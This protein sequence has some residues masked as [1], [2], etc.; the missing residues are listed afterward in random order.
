MDYFVTALQ[1]IGIFVAVTVAGVMLG[2]AVLV[3]L[4]KYIRW[5]YRKMF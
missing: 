1:V 5:I 4:V 2:A 3:P